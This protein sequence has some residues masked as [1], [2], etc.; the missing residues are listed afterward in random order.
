MKQSIIFFF[1]VLKLNILVYSNCIL[2]IPSNLHIPPLSQ[3]SAIFGFLEADDNIFLIPNHLL[4]H[5]KYYVYVPRSSKVLSFEAF[6]KSIMKIYKL[7]KVLSQSDERKRKL[8][9]EEMEKNSAKF[10]KL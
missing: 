4:L 3:D 6:L 1:I 9:P 7:E 5:F 10:V 2:H 8:F